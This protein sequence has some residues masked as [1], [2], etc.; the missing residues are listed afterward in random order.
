MISSVR[1]P[2][3]WNVWPS[4]LNSASDQPTPTAIVSRPPLSRSRLANEF[5]SASG[6]CCGSTSTLVPSPMRVVAAAAHASVI[7]GSYRKG[8]G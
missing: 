8:D 5:A 4:A 7:S 3:S 1:A 2:R 6:A